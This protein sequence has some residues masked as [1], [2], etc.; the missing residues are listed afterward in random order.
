VVV[1]VFVVEFVV[2]SEKFTQYYQED[3]ECVVV[4][5]EFVVA[6]TMERRGGDWNHIKA[7]GGSGVRVRRSRGRRGG[8]WR[9]DQYNYFI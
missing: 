1:V 8:D 4:V 2:V 6:T 3:L 5:V 9:T 7:L